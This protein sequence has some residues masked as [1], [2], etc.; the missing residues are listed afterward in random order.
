MAFTALPVAEVLHGFGIWRETVD[1]MGTI[2]VLLLM[3][4]ALDSPNAF[5]QTNNTI[6]YYS[7]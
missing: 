4:W 7:G 6:Y 3:Q 2:H 1:A 5:N